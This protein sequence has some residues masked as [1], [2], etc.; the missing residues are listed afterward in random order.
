VKEEAWVNQQAFTLIEILVVIAIIAVLASMLM[1]VFARARAKGRHATCLSNLKQIGAA[2]HSYCNDYDERFPLDAYRG[3]GAFWYERIQPYVRNMQIGVCMEEGKRSRT[4]PGGDHS[5]EWSY[6]MNSTICRLDMWGGN[7]LYDLSRIHYEYDVARMF[8]VGEG[9][10]D[11][12]PPNWF[13]PAWW[14]YESYH[15]FYHNEQSDVLFV[16]G[17]VKALGRGARFNLYPG[18]MQG[19]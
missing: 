1:P 8:M 15:K 12:M 16:D 6:A 17:H 14:Q 18:I 9:L 3:P 2:L 19:Q 4:P 11:N 10:A 7:T 13:A 5:Y